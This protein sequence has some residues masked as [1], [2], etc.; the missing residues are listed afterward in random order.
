MDFTGCC[1]LG[2]ASLAAL[3]TYTRMAASATPLP[4]TPLLPFTLMPAFNSTST[5]NA[6][7]QPRNATAHTAGQKPNLPGQSEAEPCTSYSQGNTSRNDSHDRMPVTQH[8]LHFGQDPHC[9]EQEVGCGSGSRGSSSSVR[10]GSGSC[11]QACSSLLAADLTSGSGQAPVSASGVD[12]PHGSCLSG[13]SS[14]T[15]CGSEAQP[16]EDAPNDPA[17]ELHAV[18][19][20]TVVT[21]P[22]GLTSI[23]LSGER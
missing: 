6:W 15:R 16:E 3:A 1:D 8:E 12:M 20:P 9:Q 23:I 13:R 4:A 11:G 14:S 21:G 10:G 7:L 18:G 5:S 22:L 17:Q 2:D 19:P